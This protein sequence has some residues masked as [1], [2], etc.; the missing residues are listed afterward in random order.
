M[1]PW[2]AVLA[3]DREALDDAQGVGEDECVSLTL[4]RPLAE[5]D[6][7]NEAQPLLLTVFVQ[8]RVGSPLGEPEGV[9]RAVAHGAGV[10][11]PSPER[12]AV[13]EPL[14]DPV[15][16]DAVEQPLDVPV[17]LQD[18][19]LPALAL[20]QS[21]AAE[22]ALNVGVAEGVA[23]KE[24]D[25]DTVCVTVEE[26]V[27]SPALPLP[28]PLALAAAEPVRDEEGH[29][30]ELT[31]KLHSGGDCETL[32]ETV[33]DKVPAATD[34]VPVAPPLVSVPDGDTDAARVGDTLPLTD[35]V[36]ELVAAAYD[37][38]TQALIEAH[39]VEERL[40]EPV[41]E[42]GCVGEGVAEAHAVTL[43]E[44]VSRV[45][46]LMEPEVDAERGG[47]ALDDAQLVLEG[48]PEAD[49]QRLGEVVAEGDTEAEPVV[50]SVRR[51]LAVGCREGVAVGEA[52]PAGD[53]VRGEEGETVTDAHADAVLQGVGLPLVLSQR[54]EDA[55]LE[56]DKHR[57]GVKE[58]EAVGGGEGDALGQ[59]LADAER[60]DEGLP[61]AQLVGVRERVGD[62]VLDVVID[63]VAEGLS[64]TEGVP[65]PPLP[66][67]VGARG[68]GLPLD[69]AQEQAVCVGVALCDGVALCNGEGDSLPVP[70]N[71]AE[72]LPVGEELPPT[73]AVTRTAVAV[74]GGDTEGEAQPD[75]LKEMLGVPHG[76]GVAVGQ[77]LLLDEG[78]SLRVGRALPL[79]V[80]DAHTEGDATG[81]ELPQ[82]DA[83]AVVVVVGEEETRGVSVLVPVAATAVCVGAPTLGDA[84]G[85]PLPEGKANVREG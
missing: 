27:P 74:P 60:E 73:V 58:E 34:A 62:A 81:E 19:E 72:A 77:Q 79:T 56:P 53:A 32:G 35:G 57:D 10:P 61:E 45:V 49:L 65:L 51:V 6:P 50:L 54:D 63:D 31:L 25:D 75:P 71:D 7:E 85:V 1:S 38:L 52:V 8:E 70:R 3:E 11:E 43:Q 5:G 42:G 68:V 26:R 76:V 17:T 9:P 18:G 30:E 28:L 59:P 37:A 23:E 4:K 2:E 24:G 29:G 47:E 48:D 83:V 84:E 40:G 13:R 15:A 80:A 39:V 82:G 20:P 66:V 16:T 46:A 14:D 64:A 78:A 36:I 21:D 33:G 69:V 41:A 44:A 67:V 12:E 55:L 22:E